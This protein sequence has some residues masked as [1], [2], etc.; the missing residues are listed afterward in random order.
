VMGRP[1]VTEGLLRD[2]PLED[3][4]CFDPLDPAD[5]RFF[6]LVT[7]GNSLAYGP[8]AMP[9]WVQLD[10]C[11]L[12]AAMF[13]FALPR[14]A[15]PDELWERLVQ[16]FDDLFGFQLRGAIREHV[17]YVPVSEYCAL[18]SPDGVSVVGVSLY[19][20]LPGRGLAVRTKAFGLAC[21]GAQ[22]QIGVTQY[23]NPAVATHTALAPL[24]IVAPRA[25]NH[26]DPDRSFVYELT[27]PSAPRLASFATG[28]TPGSY[29][30]A[31][32]EGATVVPLDGST[33]A[34][35]TDLLAG[36]PDLRIVAPGHASNNGET[37]LVL[38]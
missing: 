7:V 8:M 24:R 32:P 31:P 18:P 23:D 4:V 19:S 5:Q 1:E 12:P 15:V 38:A 14:S 35:V 11:T 13:G 20:L 17:G 6:R 9:L 30:A 26:T 27:V 21:L 34:I 10:C 3:V 16:R 36:N 33:A 28:A 37:G 22:R 2:A 25:V 29:P